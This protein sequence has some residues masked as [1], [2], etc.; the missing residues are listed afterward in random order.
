MATAQSMPIL[1]RS[2]I[3]KDGQWLNLVD[4]MRTAMIKSN[5]VNQLEVIARETHFIF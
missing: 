5:G 3:S 2:L 1:R 4:W